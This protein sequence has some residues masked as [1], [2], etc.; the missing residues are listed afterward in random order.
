[1]RR[2]QPW[3]LPSRSS[4]TSTC[5]PRPPELLLSRALRWGVAASAAVHEDPV[6]C[7]ENARGQAGIASL[8]SGIDVGIRRR[9]VNVSVVRRQEDKAVRKIVVSLRAA[10]AIVVARVGSRTQI[11][12]R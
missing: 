6:F 8:T 5:A 10:A 3:V 9:P 12:D 7:P 1:L 4:G 11:I 2:G